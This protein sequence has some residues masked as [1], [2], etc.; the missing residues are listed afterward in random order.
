MDFLNYK[1]NNVVKDARIHMRVSS[2]QKQIIESLSKNRNMT[3]TEY[4]LFLVNN[5]INNLK[6]KK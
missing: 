4:I 3:V 2:S 6:N 1:E 5:D